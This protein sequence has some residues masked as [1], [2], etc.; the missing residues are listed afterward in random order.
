MLDGTWREWHAGGAQ[1]IRYWSF[2]LRTSIRCRS[3]LPYHIYPAHI[4]R[5]PVRCTFTGRIS[6]EGIVAGAGGG[7]KRK[8]VGRR[9]FSIASFQLL[10]TVGFLCD[11]SGSAGGSRW[12]HCYVFSL[13]FRG[14][15]V[16]IPPE[17]TTERRRRSRRPGRCP[18][19]PAAV[20]RRRTGSP[21][22]R[23]TRRGC[24]PPPDAGPVRDFGVADNW[25]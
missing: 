23:A 15:D 7:D 14:E 17:D 21:G 12:V 10:R 24:Y 18:P 2:R 6:P 13:G 20:W 25:P 8:A 19:V 1:A 11:E 22:L 5:E 9:R 3:F 16:T 4:G